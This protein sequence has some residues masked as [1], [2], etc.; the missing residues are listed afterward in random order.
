MKETIEMLIK[1]QKSAARNFCN[2]GLLHSV[3]ANV[4]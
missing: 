4:R 2:L 1:M 3:T